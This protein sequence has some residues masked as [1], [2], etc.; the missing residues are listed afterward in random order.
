V[1]TRVSSSPLLYA[2]ILSTQGGRHIAK[3]RVT[4]LTVVE[5]FDVLPD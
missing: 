5:D 1:D 4:P 2:E 3:A